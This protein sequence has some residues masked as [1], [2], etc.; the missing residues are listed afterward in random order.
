M[1]VP[2]VSILMSVYSEPIEWIDQAISSILNQTYTDYEFVIVNDN[3]SSIKLKKYLSA[4]TLKDERIVI[5]ANKENVG[6]TKSLNKGLLVCKGKYIARMDADD[7]AYPNRLNKQV[8]FMEKY[9]NLVASGALA[10]SWYGDKK[11]KPIYRPI[12]YDEVIN[13][14]FNSSPFIHPL[15]I[16]RREVLC[17]HGITY[18]EEF[19]RSQDYKLAI[20]L[21]KIGEIANLPEYLLKY[22]VSDQQITSKY[23]YEQVILCKKIRRRYINDFYEKFNINN[24]DDEISIGTIKRNRHI[25]SKVLSR[26]KADP[27]KLLQFKR[28]MNSIRRLCYYSLSTY[29]LKSFVNFIFSGDYLKNPYNLRRFVVIL[30]KHFKSDFIPKLL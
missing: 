19:N 21:L 28:A 15:L 13:Y 25:E 8:E 18:D 1:Q 14:T 12:T 2:S 20:D 23:G 17:T 27:S 4:L 16:I 6:L 3:P 11:L 5:L 26:I 24:L 22:R 10:Y 30:V 7:W 9:P 29:S